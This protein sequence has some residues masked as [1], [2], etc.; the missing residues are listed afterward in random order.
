MLVN[1]PLGGECCG[2]SVRAA[3]PSPTHEEATES[4]PQ[5]KNTQQRQGGL[6]PRNKSHRGIIPQLLAKSGSNKVAVKSKQQLSNVFSTFV[7]RVGRNYGAFPLR[8]RGHAHAPQPAW[9]RLKGGNDLSAQAH[10][11]SAV[12]MLLLICRLLHGLG[13]RR[14]LNSSQRFSMKGEAEPPAGAL[15]GE[16]G[17]QNSNPSPAVG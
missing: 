2:G 12:R 14:R 10:A 4:L 9:A 11:G 3:P 6:L 16:S 1:S 7:R 8:E 5:A 13:E 15:A 17:G